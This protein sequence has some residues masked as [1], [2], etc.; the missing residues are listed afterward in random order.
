MIKYEHRESPRGSYK[1]SELYNEN[2]QGELFVWFERKQ[3]A[4]PQWT[5]VWQASQHFCWIKPV[6]LM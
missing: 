2:Q 1:Q 6:R 3:S 5:E 4:V